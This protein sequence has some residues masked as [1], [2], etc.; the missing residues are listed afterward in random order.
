MNN[1]FLVS[2]SI[3]IA[4]GLLIIAIFALL[5]LIFHP[6][7]TDKN[8]QPIKL[9]VSDSSLNKSSASTPVSSKS[10]SQLNSNADIASGQSANSQ[11]ISKS[12]STSSGGQTVINVNGQQITVPNNAS[13]NKTI[14]NNNQTTK[15][16]VDNNS[17]SSGSN[18][19]S[20]INVHSYSSGNAD[21]SNQV[22]V[23]QTDG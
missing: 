10:N 15:I 22:S 17:S 2:L 16:S 7:S 23:N 20:S 6:I 5:Y 19:S 13:Y 4:K 18:V 14:V 12:T 3:N 8:L 21:Q 11:V 9:G 1:S